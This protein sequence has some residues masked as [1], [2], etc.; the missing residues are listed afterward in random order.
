MAIP[1]RLIVAILRWVVKTSRSAFRENVILRKSEKR[2]IG[3]YLI[4]M[5]RRTSL[6]R[7]RGI[8]QMVRIYKNGITHQ[9]WH[10]VV[11]AGKIIHKHLTYER[12]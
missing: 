11:R 10:I 12:K 1:P 2:R 3:R 6:G 8:S 4:E 9:V 7:D 5:E